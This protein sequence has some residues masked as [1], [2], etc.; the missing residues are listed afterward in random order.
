MNEA[1]TGNPTFEEALLRLEQTVRE[2][3]DGRLGLEESLACYEQGI[4]LIRFC[5]TRLQDAE[6]RI[7]QLTGVN[8]EGEPTLQPFQH[9]ATVPGG[10]TNRRRTS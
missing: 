7:L 5:H 9:E 8:S 3:E 10:S 6:Q 4:Q 1:Q 2:L